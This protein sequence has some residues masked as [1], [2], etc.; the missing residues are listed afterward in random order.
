LE[1]VGDVALQ[2]TCQQE[3]HGMCVFAVVRR[4]PLEVAEKQRATRGFA[5]KTL[6]VHDAM[7]YTNPPRSRFVTR[8]CGSQALARV[9]ERARNAAPS[10]QGVKRGISEG[11]Q[12]SHRSRF[13]ALVTLALLP[14]V[15]TAHVKWFVDYDLSS[16][17]RPALTVVS[18]RYF[19]A[20]CVVLVPLMFAVA[21]VDRYLT[22]RECLLHRHARLATQRLSPYFPLVLR[23]GVAAFF[24][25]VFVYG[26]LGDAM[27][28]TPE[29]HTH[30]AW[31][32]WLQ[33]AIALLALPRATAR[34]AGLGIVALYAY[35]IAAYG[36]FHMLDYPI[37]LGVAAYLIVDS[38]RA[39]HGREFAESTVR[40]AAG[41]T[42]LWASIE[43]FAFP[44]WSFILLAQR[45]GM[46]F[47]FNPEF[48][49]VAAGFVE[50]CAAYLL[51]TGRL[52]ARVAALVLLAM[53]L[54]AIVPFGRIDAIGH[55]VIIVV[56]LLLA[57]G[58]NGVARY[59]EIRGRASAT[60]TLQA[61]VFFG[62]LALFLALYYAGYYLSYAN[63][64]R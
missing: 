13:A 36:L 48:Y 47:G 30:N 9:R 12:P 31:I 28:L 11:M 55:S 34:Y 45:P 42:L 64:A 51:V 57:F 27:I 32:C 49:M 52:S 18:G 6:T 59:F 19:I 50:F 22:R 43:K 39:E 61:S 63:G 35:G 1:Y 46:T 60:A 26:C 44:E 56:L 38:Y 2:T 25:A 14:A 8:A 3:A 62:A 33:L 15:A 29:L 24:M 58:D 40:I 54:W 37:F 10:S 20:F 53:F 16:P 7:S 5:E 4:S 17:P 23:S 41:V 21:L